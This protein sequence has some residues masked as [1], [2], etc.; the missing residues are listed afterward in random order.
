MNDSG[1]SST[2]EFAPTDGHMGLEVKG[3]RIADD[4]SEEAVDLLKKKL[5]N[6]GLL[7]F[8]GQQPTEEER[9]RITRA[10]GETRGHPVP[11]VGG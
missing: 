7:V 8:H 10:F 1:S 4:I 6:H 5:A 11:G 9:I 2:I 3:I